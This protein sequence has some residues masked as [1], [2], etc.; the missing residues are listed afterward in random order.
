MIS[1][2]ITMKANDDNITIS[3]NIVHDNYKIHGNRYDNNDNNKKN[4]H[5]NNSIRVN[6]N[7]NRSNN[8]RSIAQKKIVHGI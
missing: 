2:I 3:S 5:G 6:D 4:H 7:S 8:G 1:M